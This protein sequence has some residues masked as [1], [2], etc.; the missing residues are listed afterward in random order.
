MVFYV[1]FCQG[2]YFLL[3]LF[4]C[5]RFGISTVNK[6]LLVFEFT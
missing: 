3:V 2:L 4:T 5:V 6:E 1:F